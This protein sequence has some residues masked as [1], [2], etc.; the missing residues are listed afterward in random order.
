MEEIKAKWA[1][2]ETYMEFLQNNSDSLFVETE[3]YGEIEIYGADTLITGQHGYAYNPV[4]QQNID[5]WNSG[6]VV[7]ASAWGDPFCIDISKENSPVY[8]AFHGEDEWDFNE[9]YA[10][11][12]EFLKTMVK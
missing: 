12:E 4:T 3:E 8:Y 11:L 6:F 9:E 7:I 5:D 2:P 10:S 1:L